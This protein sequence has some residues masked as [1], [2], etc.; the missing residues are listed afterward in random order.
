MN[1]ATATS[2][3]P[4]ATT[5]LVPMRPTSSGLSGAATTNAAATGSRRTPDCS[6]SYPRPNCKYWDR[7]NSA[8]NIEKNTNVTAADAAENLGFLKNVTSSIGWS[9]R[10][11]HTM[12]TASNTTPIANAPRI[13]GSVQPRFGPSMIPYSSA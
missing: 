2:T 1:I 11:S 7:K 5:N 4:N 3:R 13:T 9:E 12:N 8:P 10:A 6:A